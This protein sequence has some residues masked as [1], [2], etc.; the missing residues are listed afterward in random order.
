[1]SDFL[2]DPRLVLAEDAWFEAERAERRGDLLQSSVCYERAANL[3]AEV[4][5]AMPSE[6]SLRELRGV[7]AINAAVMTA[8]ARK[9]GR[10]ID[11]IDRFLVD[12]DSFIERDRLELQRMLE[13]YRKRADDRGSPRH[14][15]LLE[16]RARI[17]RDAAA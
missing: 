14:T 17:R 13:D 4:V 1:M 11:L 16:Q 9:H 5:F 12:G 8:R 2:E 6:Q 15:W 3:Y 7:W 10:A